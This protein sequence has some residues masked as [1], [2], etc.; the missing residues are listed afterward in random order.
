VSFRANP[1]QAKR[2]EGGAEESQHF[3]HTATKPAT[4]E[5][6]KSTTQQ[7]PSALTPA[8]QTLETRLRD[9]RSAEAERLGMPQFFVLG[10]ST[11]RN[12]ALEQP[13]T[14]AHLKKVDG[15]SL[16]K[17]EKFGS[18]ILEICAG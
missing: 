9:W 15:V 13:R 4:V 14:L 12:I 16:E 18:S 8:Q 10:S 2:A 1:E 6:S 5:R 3:A 11:L 17:A 7:Q